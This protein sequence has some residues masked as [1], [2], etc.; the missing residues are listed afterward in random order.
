MRLRIVAAA[1]LA[2][3]AGSA[4]AA[5][6][7][8]LGFTVVVRARARSRP[9]ASERRASRTLR[10]RSRCPSTGPTPPAD[11]AALSTR[12]A[13][14]RSGSAPAPP[15]G[16][17][18]RCSPRSTRSSRTS[19]A[20]WARARPAR[21]AGC[22][23]CRRPGC[24]G[25]STPTATASPTRGTPTDAVYSA[26]R[27]LAA[28]GGQ[29]D[30]SRGDLRL[31]PRRL[32]RPRG[33]RRS[34]S[35]YGDG[36]SR[37]PFALDQLQAKLDAARAARRA[38]ERRSSIAAQTAERAPAGPPRSDAARHAPTSARCSPTGSPP[39]S[40]R[41]SS[42]PAST[43][44]TRRASRRAAGR[45]R[46]AQAALERR[47]AERAAR[48]RSRRRVG[49]SLGAPSYTGG[50]VFPVG[51][52][53]GSR[54]RL[55]HPPRLSGRRHRRARGLA[56]LRARGRGRAR[57][58]GRRPTRA[59]ASASRSATRDGQVWTYCHL[60]FLDP[61]V[62]DGATLAAGSR[63]GLVGSTGHATGPHLHL[64]LQPATA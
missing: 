45:S 42:T 52:G 32:V 47:A 18:G 59:A 48:R 60:S 40:A 24:A 13:A 41:R 12:R 17:R 2:V 20:T 1:A 49:S 25:A 36:R 61:N 26:A 53:P 23:S 5:E 7:P 4:R 46:Q 55:A 14:R 39:S 11:P 51:G 31:Q 34:R 54:L 21:S 19:A 57:T 6:P 3:L 44:R 58:P 16:S 43:P 10:A 33:A 50:Y 8:V 63:S 15:T 22:S 56:A 27:Y 9:C 37:R 38:R 64:Q 62:V 29:T 35:V 28:A 30:I